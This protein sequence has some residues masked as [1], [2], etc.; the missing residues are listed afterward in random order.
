VN[1]TG[2]GRGK[3]ILF[4][5]HSAVYGYPA[6]GLPLPCRTEISRRVPDRNIPEDKDHIIEILLE[7]AS[8]FLPSMKKT[9]AADLQLFSNVPR[10]GGFGSSAA[11][12]VALSRFIL[13]RFS[14]SYDR[15][16][17]QMANRMEKHFHGTPSGIDTGMASDTS[18]ALWSRGKKNL[19][20]RHPLDIPEWHL[21]Y[22]ALPRIAATDKSVGRIRNLQESGNKQ[23]SSAM[24]ELGEI[25]SEF[26]NYTENNT[27]ED[28][29][30]K[31]AILAN[32]AQSVL[33]SLNL[34]TK[35]LDSLLAQAKGMGALGGKLSG[36]GMGG[37]FYLC[38]PNLKIRDNIISKL[39]EKLTS[40]GIKLTLPLTA[41]DFPYS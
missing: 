24:E 33:S 10:T 13:N 32:Q 9:A 7:K 20:E 15:E 6:V 12:C 16:V 4:G 39:P 29:P 19:P 14:N 17:H 18:T 41:L 11:L 38:T 31:A 30:Y 21:I 27:G 26:I 3:L 34:S 40:L 22:G 25:T 28:F 36:G 8:S 1:R 5:E 35:E 2:V 37:A 23:F